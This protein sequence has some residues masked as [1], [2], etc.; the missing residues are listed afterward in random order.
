MKVAVHPTWQQV[1]ERFKSSFGEAVEVEYGGN[2][3][4]L[5]ELEL[6]FLSGEIEDLIQLKKNK[7]FPRYR[8]LTNREAKK[9]V[10]GNLSESDETF[11]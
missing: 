6:S 2:R 4:M 10:R 11:R 5:L 7:V 1:G 3:F 8:L 9:F